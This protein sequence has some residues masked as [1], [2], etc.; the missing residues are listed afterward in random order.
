MQ[1]LPD[2]AFETYVNLGS[3]R[4]YQAIADTYGV[5]KRTVV[6]TAEREAW[7]ARLKSIEQR[8]REAVDEK[9][10]LEMQERKLRQRKL[11]VAMA[12]RAAK[13]LVDYPLTSGMEGIRAAERAIKLERLLDG[14]ATEN[15]SVD[16][17][18]VIRRESQELLSVED[19]EPDPDEVD[20]E[21]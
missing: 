12:S 6:R 11:V 16:I 15:T 17:E 19:E 18:Q 9:L 5:H 13:A 2:G 21:D 20:E 7:A 10:A 14:E 1:R 4:S 3:G 8:A